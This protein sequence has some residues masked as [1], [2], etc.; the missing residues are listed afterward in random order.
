M[1][2]IVKETKHLYQN[3]FE[4]IAHGLNL[5][6]TN[7]VSSMPLEEVIKDLYNVTP[8]NIDKFYNH[9]IKGI[10]GEIIDFATRAQA[11][12][13]PSDIEI[14]Y[15][16]KVANRDL[17]EAVK[18][19]KHLQKN[20]IEYSNSTNK[21]I[22][23]QYNT[24]RADLAEL[25]RNINII[26]TTDEDDTIMLLLA[27]VKVHAKRY[28][29]IANG[30]LDNLIRNSLITN[31]MAT[32]LMND[33]TYAYNISQKLSEMAEIIFTNRDENMKSLNKEMSMSDEDIQ[34]IIN[35]KD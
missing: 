4:I 23:E 3:A 26:A 32:S 13:S 28:D 34:S 27:K 10:Y 8:I 20:L 19:T 16:L 5:K 1:A 30:T 25:L 17:V 6:R 12:M 33:S 15:E 31:E 35:Q 14:L 2:A 18:D 24:M 29:I 7:I 22:K 21:Y 9:K 11:D